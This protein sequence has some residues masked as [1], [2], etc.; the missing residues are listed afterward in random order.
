MTFAD[1][2]GGAE[3]SDVLVQASF[4]TIDQNDVDACRGGAR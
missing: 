1:D 4:V 2:L 3:Y